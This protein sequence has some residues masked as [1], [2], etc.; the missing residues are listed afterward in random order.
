MANEMMRRNDWLEDPFFDNLG[1]RFFEDFM[2]TRTAA[3]QVLNTDIKET[4][5]DYVAKVDVPGI[6]KDDIKLNYQDNILNISVKKNDFN[7]HEDKDGNLLMSERHYGAMSRSYRLPNVDE[8]AIKAA[9]ADG[10]LTITLPKL[11][12]A[13]HDNHQIEIN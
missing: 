11:T 12:E 10:V 7:D 4:D 2:P 13:H 3:D 1:R 6:A 8:A 9:Y 5:H